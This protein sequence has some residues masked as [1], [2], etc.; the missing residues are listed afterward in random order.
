MSVPARRAPL[1]TP[2][3]TSGPVA[4]IY[5]LRYMG[6]L[7]GVVF[8]SHQIG[9]FPGAWLGGRLY[10]AYGSYSTVWRLGVAI[11]LFSALAHLPVRERPMR[12]TPAE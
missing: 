8:F 1:V 12:L 9:A 11:S 5:G 3:L 10:D 6:T 2:V 4:Q 7:Y